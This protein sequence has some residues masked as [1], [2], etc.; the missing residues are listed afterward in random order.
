MVI[1]CALHWVP[2]CPSASKLEI[3]TSPTN[4]ESLEIWQWLSCSRSTRRFISW[5][6]KVRSW[7]LSE[8]VESSPRPVPLISISILPSHL[9]ESGWLSRYS[10]WVMGW[11]TEQLQF[12]FG[13]GQETSL[14]GVK[15]VDDVSSFPWIKPAHLHL[16]SILRM[17][18][19]A[20]L[21]H[22][23]SLLGVKLD[24]VCRHVCF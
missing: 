9:R 21:S 8:P 17:R 12:D 18:D 14:H 4:Q 22:M 19:G 20:P 5:F 24:T 16:M 15:C 11:M 13:Q 10:D 1:W 6:T 2:P 7:S 3:I 23:P